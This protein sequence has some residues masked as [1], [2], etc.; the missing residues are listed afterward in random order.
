MPLL[1]AKQKKINYK[2]GTE[3]SLTNHSYMM[4]DISN[5]ETSIN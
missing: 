2:G 4:K 1:E 3:P 5:F